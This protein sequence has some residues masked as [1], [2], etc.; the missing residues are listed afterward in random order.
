MGRLKLAVNYLQEATIGYEILKQP[1]VLQ[2]TDFSYLFQ[3][4]F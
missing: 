4:P 2:L 3:P 1:C